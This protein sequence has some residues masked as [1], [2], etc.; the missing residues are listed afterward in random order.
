MILV[1]L[2]GTVVRQEEPSG[3]CTGTR[4]RDTPSLGDFAKTATLTANDHFT[5]ANVALSVPRRADAVRPVN[6]FNPPEPTVGSNPASH[7]QDFRKSPTGPADNVVSD[8]TQGVFDEE[9]LEGRWTECL[10][11]GVSG[12]NG[13]V[14]PI[15][16]F[17]LYHNH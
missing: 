12:P 2:D 1:K 15:K 11:S 4:S 8:P 17:Y 16:S 6:P 10:S 5:N 7:P 14:G 3:D 9:E 13:S